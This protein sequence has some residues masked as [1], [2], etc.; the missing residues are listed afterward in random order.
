MPSPTHEALVVLFR[1]CPALGLHLVRALRSDIPANSEVQVVSAEFAELV[2]AEY[3]ADVVLRVDDGRGNAGDVLI[4]EAQLQRD[5]DK[6]YTWHLYAAGARNRFRCPAT[7]VAVTLD[8]QVARWCAQPVTVDRAGSTFQ[9]LVLGPDQIPVITNVE[10]ARAFPELAVL[11]AMAHGREEGAENIALAAL[12]GCAPLDDAHGSLYADIIHASMGELARRA[13]ESLMEQR[14]YTYQTDF[15]RKH[16][17]EGRRVGV[18]EGRTEGREEGRRVGDA[19]GRRALLLEQLEAR[20]G[21]LPVEA[22]TLVEQAP[23][24]VISAWGRRVL[25]V[26]RLSAV[27]VPET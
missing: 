18:E 7:V 19:E 3:R 5:G 1:E 10:Q 24:E 22:V 15:A 25:T 14:N 21:K 27:F 20:F 8:E 23:P 17:G 9:P 2:P 12:A 16:F 6:F 11:S 4:V 26:D 13:L